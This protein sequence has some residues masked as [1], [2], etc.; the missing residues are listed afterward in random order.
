[1]GGCCNATVLENVFSRTV[2]ATQPPE[3]VFSGMVLSTTSENQF[4]I[5]EFEISRQ[6]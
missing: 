6:I 2:V 4:Q 1:M 3:N 5:F